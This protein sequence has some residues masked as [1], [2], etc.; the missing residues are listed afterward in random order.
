MPPCRTSRCAALSRRG[1]GRARQNA[2]SPR[3]EDSPRVS[4]LQRTKCVS[5]MTTRGTGLPFSIFAIKCAG[6]NSTLAKP[7]VDFQ[8]NRDLDCR[9]IRR[10]KSVVCQGLASEGGFYLPDFPR[11]Q[12]SVFGPDQ[13]ADERRTRENGRGP[14]RWFCWPKNTRGSQFA[15]RILNGRAKSC[16]PRTGFQSYGTRSRWNASAANPSRLGNCS[17]LGSRHI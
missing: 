2:K 12:R 17:R 11:R 4:C 9:R 14:I 15:G 6:L 8:C 7:S 16:S 1:T 13:C 10:R 5:T 3:R